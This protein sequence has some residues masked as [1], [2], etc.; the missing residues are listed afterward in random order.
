MEGELVGSVNYGSDTRRPLTTYR[1]LNLL[2]MVSYGVSI[3]LNIVCLVVMVLKHKEM[4]D[5]A[6]SGYESEDEWCILF[7]NKEGNRLKY[8][9]NKCHLVIYGSAAL[10]GCAFLMIIFLLIKTMLFR[11]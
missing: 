9:N 7:M 6:G 3:V 11:K 1:M 4:V 8:V 2:L 10:A 5:K